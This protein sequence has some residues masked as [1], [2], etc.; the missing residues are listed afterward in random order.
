M[1]DIAVPRL[2]SNDT[3][4][5]LVEWLVED[6][7]TVRAGDPLAVLESSK[8]AQEIEAHRDGVLERVAAAGADYGIGHVIGRIFASPQE[9]R[10]AA[11]PPT[12]DT[13][14][15][16][17][18]DLVVTLP[19]RALAAELGIDDDRLRSLGRR[20]IRRSD[21]E[22]LAASP[23]P[24]PA[25]RLVRLSANQ[26]AV[27]AV[28]TASHA[29]IPAAF[30]VVNVAV[31]A[32]LEYGRTARRRH[33]ALVGLTE[34]VVKALGTLY[35][36]HPMLYGSLVDPQTVRLA[37]GA[38]V[39]VTLDVGTGL[40]VPVVRDAHRRPLAEVAADTM[41]L[42]VSAL[43]GRFDAAELTGATIMVAVTGDDGVLLTQPVILPG[44]T[45]AV[46]L[47]GVRREYAP[48]PDGDTPRLRAVMSIGLAYD[49]RVV[50]GRQAVAFLNAVKSRVEHPE[51]LDDD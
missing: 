1:A 13:P 50:N 4:Y 8:A 14:A 7:A 39:G 25:G 23:A 36:E 9:R 49:H 28:V 12:V 46:S 15:V 45:C 22:E 3:T 26:A 17:A 29:T 24:E 47:G 19:A 51:T 40:Y 38:H 48:G 35:A 2:N 20:L 27:A 34:I 11:P 32:A 18:D 31:D 6:G 5:S 41:R 42:R 37:D 16:P 44:L 10:A 33:R 30:S 43:N 21:V